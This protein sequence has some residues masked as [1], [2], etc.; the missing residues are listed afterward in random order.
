MH[1]VVQCNFRP[2]TCRFGDPAS[3]GEKNRFGDRPLFFFLCR[4]VS[5]HPEMVPAFAAD[6]CRSVIRRY[7]V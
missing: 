5:P 6:P 4:N 2:S 1:P 7:R 3:A